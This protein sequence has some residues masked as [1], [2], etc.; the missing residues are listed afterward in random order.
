M[1]FQGI[2]QSPTLT[3]GSSWPASS[4]S[5]QGQQK[6]ATSRAVDPS[7]AL[8]A[9]QPLQ[10]ADVAD[11]PEVELV[12]HRPQDLWRPLE[13]ERVVDPLD[14]RVGAVRT[15]LRLELEVAHLDAAL[16][17]RFADQ[18]GAADL[19]G[20]HDLQVIDEED[21]DAAG[22]EDVVD[23]GLARARLRGREAIRADRPDPVR[24]VEDRD[25]E[26]VGDGRGVPE[27]LE[28]R[29][30]PTTDDLAQVL[31]EGLG[32]GQVERAQATL[33]ELGDEVQGDDRLAGARDRPR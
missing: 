26:P 20:A 24:L 10:L 9:D 2:D 4:G 32:A 17:G 3:S 28:Q 6:P 11:D 16:R 1:A 25:V 12:V 19:A 22:I 13:L 33:G 8:S 15:E 27:V 14:E 31:G 30:G 5:D 7:P 18:V 29:A 23:L 21:G